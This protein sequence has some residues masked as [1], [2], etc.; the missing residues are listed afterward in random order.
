MDRGE[1]PDA[2]NPL[3][4]MTVI[5]AAADISPA[6]LGSTQGQWWGADYLGL[7]EVE[8]RVS[9]VSSWKGHH[10]WTASFRS[11]RSGK[12][13]GQRFFLTNKEGQRLAVFNSIEDREAYFQGL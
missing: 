5:P 6:L 7:P 11:E 2:L 3:T 9:L 8:R 13:L 12:F 1:I 4:A 10:C